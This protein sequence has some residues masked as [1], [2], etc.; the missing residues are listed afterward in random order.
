[1][2]TRKAR[3]IVL[4]TAP[5]VPPKAPSKLLVPCALLAS[6][7]AFPTTLSLLAVLGAFPA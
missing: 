3:P 6:L 4:S 7:L 2:V 1:M 5:S